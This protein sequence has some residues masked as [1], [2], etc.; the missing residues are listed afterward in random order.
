MIPSWGWF[1]IGFTSYNVHTNTYHAWGTLQHDLR[2]VSSI[3]QRWGTDLKIGSS[4]IVP[5]RNQTCQLEMQGSMGKSSIKFSQRVISCNFPL[6]GWNIWSIWSVTHIFAQPGPQNFSH[7]GLAVLLHCTSGHSFGVATCP[8][9][10]VGQVGSETIFPKAS[11]HI[12]ISNQQF[13]WY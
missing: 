5:F 11:G 6:R 12:N 8:T 4:V 3:F 7:P 2:P 13:S 1:T 9:Q 10:S